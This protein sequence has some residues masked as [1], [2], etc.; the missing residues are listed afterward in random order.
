M[1]KMLFFTFIFILLYLFI[2]IAYRIGEF[3]N[4]Y[5]LFLKKPWSF[6]SLYHDPNGDRDIQDVPKEQ[7]KQFLLYCDA[8]IFD[9]FPC[10]VETKEE[11]KKYLS[12]H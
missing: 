4:N 3:D 2:G 12:E 9:Q 6:Q 5:I 7:L 10:T 8:N 1:N 11:V